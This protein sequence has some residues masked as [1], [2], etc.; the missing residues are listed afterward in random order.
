MEWRGVRTHSKENG[1]RQAVSLVVDE[2]LALLAKEVK[3]LKGVND[4]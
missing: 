4:E 2:L 3:L 1:K